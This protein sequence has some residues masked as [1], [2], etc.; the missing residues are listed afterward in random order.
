MLSPL[1]SPAYIDG[2]GPV[3]LGSGFI[4]S[5]GC[6]CGDNLRVRSASR[7][8]RAR[9]HT[10]K[11]LLVS[12]I[13][14]IIIVYFLCSL[15]FRFVVL[16]LIAVFTALTVD[17]TGQGRPACVW[18]WLRRGQSRSHMLQTHPWQKSQTMSINDTMTNLMLSQDNKHRRYRLFHVRSSLLSW[19]LDK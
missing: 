15:L 1:I 2:A 19:D 17:D 9:C 11:K 8:A 18:C 6:R 4:N 7:S 16:Y 12:L 10:V 5:A 3:L 14:W 13:F